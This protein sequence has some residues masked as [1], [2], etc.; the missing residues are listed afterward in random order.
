MTMITPS[1]FHADPLGWL[2]GGSTGQAVDDAV[3]NFKIV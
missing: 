2:R 1:N 3:T